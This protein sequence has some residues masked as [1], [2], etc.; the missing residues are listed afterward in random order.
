MRVDNT[1]KMEERKG[2]KN[3]EQER[4]LNTIWGA[5]R[6][7]EPQRL[8]QGQSGRSMRAKEEKVR[9]PG[10]RFSD[11]GTSGFRHSPGKGCYPE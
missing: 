10:H 1:E 3:G 11:P 6:K 7:E 8:R 4:K 9:G 5:V 2:K